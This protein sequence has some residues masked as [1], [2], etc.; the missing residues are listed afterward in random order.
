MVQQTVEDRGGE[1]SL[2]EYLTPIGVT[3]VGGQNDTA[4]L[5]AGRDRLEE[6]RG[7]YRIQRQIAYFIYDQHFGFEIMPQPTFQLSFP[8]R[9]SRSVT[10][11]WAVAK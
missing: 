7:S 5:I 4:P 6:D 2:S 10:R 9:F 11:L 8:R 1:G 3:L